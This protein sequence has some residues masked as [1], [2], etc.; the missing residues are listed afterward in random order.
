MKTKSFLVSV[1]NFTYPSLNNLASI[2][3]II[4]NIVCYI[5]IPFT[6]SSKRPANVFKIHVLI[7]GRLLDRVNT[8]L[9]FEN[10]AVACYVVLMRYLTSYKVYRPIQQEHDYQHRS[11]APMCQFLRSGFCTFA[12]LT[13]YHGLIVQCCC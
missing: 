6:R 12:C 3:I 4:A 11:P 2:A 5:N 1:L 10:K 7:A 13:W 9:N 8:L